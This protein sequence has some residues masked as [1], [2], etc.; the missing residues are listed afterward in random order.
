MR[1]LIYLTDEELKLMNYVL[2]Q[3]SKESP[4]DKVGKL[5]K[6]VKQAVIL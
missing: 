5:L 6:K 3:A 1:V 4:D 2:L